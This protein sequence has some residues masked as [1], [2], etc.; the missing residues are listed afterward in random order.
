MKLAFIFPGQAS[1]YVG[2]GQDLRD[3]FPEVKA[4][5]DLTDE[6]L[7]TEISHL[8]F[9]GPLEELTRTENTQ[10]AI[11][12]HSIAVLRLLQKE[13][14][15]PLVVAGHSLGEYTALVAAEVLPYETALP[16]VQLRGRLMQEAGEK[17]PG[18]MAAVIG[19]SADQ[20]Q[21][22]CA[23]AVEAGVVQVAN[24]NSPTQVVISGEAS[25]VERAMILAKE[26]GAKRVIGLPVSGAFHSPLMASARESLAMALE[27]TEFREPRVPV[28][29]NV[30]AQVMEKPEH[31]RELLV[32]QLVEPVRW[33]QSVLKMV[34]MGMEL[35]LEVGPGNV[36]QNLIRRIAPRVETMGVDGVESLE[37]A[38]TRC[39]EDISQL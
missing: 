8:S 13:G 29:A 34:E 12:A 16:L 31:I 32:Q 27:K 38:L 3:R 1:Q 14:L 17:R 18:T 19:L 10:P 21:E 2:M 33:S 9:H 25:G 4:H 39:A 20:V 6:I 22:L 36:L 37:L 7:G 35:C 5:Y 26:A 11:F 15:M 23:R 30:T 24:I 28:V